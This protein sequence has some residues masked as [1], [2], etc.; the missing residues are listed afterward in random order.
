MNEL[1]QMIRDAARDF[2]QGEVLAGAEARDKSHAFPREIVAK[3]GELGLLGMLVPE[4]WGGAGAD[5]Q[6]LVLAIEEVAAADGAISTIMSVQNSLANMCINSFGTEA[7]KEQFLRPLAEG[8]IIGG[9]ALTEPHAGS[10]A[11]ALRTTAKRDGNEYVLNGHKQ[12]I[13]SGKEGDVIIVFAVT[14]AAAGRKGMSAFIV[15]VETKGYMVTRLEEKMGQHCSDTAAISFEDMRIPAAYRLG[16]EGEG[17]KIALSNLEGGRIGIAAQCL[18]MARAAL[19][20]ALAYAQERESFGKPIIQHQAVGF[21]LAQM[22]TELEAAR[23]L[24]HHAARLR[25]SGAACLKEA[26]MAKLFASEAGERIVREAI[27]VLG[28]YGYVSDFPMERIYRDIRVCT[29]YEGTSDIQKLIITRELS[30]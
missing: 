26:C 17:Y 18:G 8:R 1:Q 25:D 22:A 12:F 30:K 24:V 16:E 7:Q 19:E 4:Q 21:R 13:T 5:Y 10:D 6:S 11:G 15:P 27:Q 3:M 28:G 14:D 29:L 2:A 23:Q 20:G 9:F